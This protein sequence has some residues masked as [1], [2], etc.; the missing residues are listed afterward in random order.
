MESNAIKSSLILYQKVFQHNDET[1]H[2][3]FFGILKPLI[4]SFDL[5]QTT[6]LTFLR[7]LLVCSSFLFL[8]IY[9]MYTIY[10]NAFRLSRTLSTNFHKFYLYHGVFMFVLNAS[11]YLPYI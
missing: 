2:R 3:F 1:Q 10:L 5:V 9:S 11:F 7:Y 4:I 8:R 6:I